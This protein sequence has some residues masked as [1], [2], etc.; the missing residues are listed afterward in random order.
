[1]KDTV[2]GY[3]VRYEKKKQIMYARMDD[4]MISN[5]REISKKTGIS[6]S[7]LIRESVRRMLQE[8]DE[9]GS[10]QLKLN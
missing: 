5:L 6:T 10:I 8:V 9:T 2:E 3:K 7:E 1:M 4:S